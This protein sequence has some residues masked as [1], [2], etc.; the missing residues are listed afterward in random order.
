M[1]ISLRHDAVVGAVYLAEQL[2]HIRFYYLAVGVLGVDA[3]VKIVGILHGAD[4]LLNIGVIFYEL[5]KFFEV[6]GADLDVVHGV[7]KLVHD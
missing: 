7:N 1:L 6:V 3:H 4:I 2:G 5:L